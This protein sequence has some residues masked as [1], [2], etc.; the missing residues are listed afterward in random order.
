MEKKEIPQVE[1]VKVK[2]FLGMKPGLWLT[3]L[4]CFIIIAV[5]FAVGILPDMLHGSVRVT[6]ENSGKTSAVYV[7]GNYVCATPGTVKVAS[8]NHT[9][10]YRI[11]EVQVDEFSIS[12]PHP[13]FF[14]WLFPRKMTINRNAEIKD[15][16]AFLALTRE[17]FLDVAAYSA[18]RNYDN[19]YKYP[20]L[21]TNYVNTVK[22]TGYSM[23]HLHYAL[24]F[25]TTEEMLRDAQ[26]AYAVLNIDYDFSA[27]EDAVKNESFRTSSPAVYDSLKGASH[28]EADGFTV[29]GYIYGTG[30]N[31]FSLSEMPVNETMYAFF[32]KDNPEWAPENK[33]DLISKGLVDDQYLSGITLTTEKLS[34][35]AITNISYF[36]AKAFCKWLTGKTGRT[37][38][39][40]SE[41]EWT[42]A[43]SNA[44]HSFL[45]TST[46][47]T[48]SQ[49]GPVG[50]FGGVWEFTSTYY[51]PNDNIF[52]DNIQAFLN[53]ND[54]VVSP[55]V[56]GGSYL[57]NPDN[58]SSYT[59]GI[60]SP[61]LCTDT[62]GF[63][64]AWK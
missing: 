15:S 27:L 33:E 58:I 37:V 51:V 14:N 22:D 42:C 21:F 41:I 1:P 28:L 26:A 12:V 64:I 34:Y 45:K 16:E 8:G 31:E 56:K 38:Y 50:M 61:S 10:N 60:V 40:P 32:V 43:S 4:Y 5:I 47:I 62:Y 53:A 20:P 52:G 7:D 35:K 36:A 23:D 2:P 9:V 29:L 57:S 11:A 48:S 17:F 3:I 55:I 59:I 18:V 13:I 46:P 54:F 63:R 39:L 25:I 49:A 44:N 24:E 19:V 6:F 30:E